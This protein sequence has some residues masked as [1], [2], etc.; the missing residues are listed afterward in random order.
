MRNIGE[1]ASPPGRAG[2]GPG[3]FL[4][5]VNRPGANLNLPFRL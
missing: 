1:S 5:P 2:V 3:R 4:A